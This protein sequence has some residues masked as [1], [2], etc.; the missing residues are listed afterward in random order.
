[1]KLLEHL[2]IDGNEIEKQRRHKRVN[3]RFYDNGGNYMIKIIE[4]DRDYF[5]KQV[6]E[7]KWFMRRFLY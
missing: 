2:I 6:L 4:G 7:S 3:A 1:M 5:Y